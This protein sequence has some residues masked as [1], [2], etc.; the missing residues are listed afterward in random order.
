MCIE[1]QPPC[2]P[3]SAMV[4]DVD[5]FSIRRNKEAQVASKMAAIGQTTVLKTVAQSAAEQY[6]RKDNTYYNWSL[7]YPA[8]CRS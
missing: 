3:D 4:Y 6:D 2:I 1:Q 7:T 8:V 5:G